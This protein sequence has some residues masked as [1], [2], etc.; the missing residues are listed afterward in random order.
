[1]GAAR[2]S[3]SSAEITIAHGGLSMTLSPFGARLVELQVPDTDGIHDDVVLGLDDVEAYARHRNVYLGATIGRVA[4]RI[5]G[6]RFSLAGT[7]YALARNEGGNH[8]HGGETRS[9]DRV[10]WAVEELSDDDLAVVAGR[11]VAFS[12][13][14]P[15]LEEGYPGALNARAAYVLSG[16]RE[17]WTI[18]TATC[19]RPCPV[20]LTHHTYWNLAGGEVEILGH[21]LMVAASEVLAVTGELLP[22]GG[23]VAVEDTPLD[24]RRARPV[25]AWLPPGGEPWPGIDHTYVLD[26]ADGSLSLAAVLGDPDSGRT[27]EIHTTEPLLQ[28]YTANRLHAFVGR[29]GRRYDVGHAV[30]LE[31]QR[32]PDAVNR[33]E[34][35]SAVLAPGETYRHV[36]CYRFGFA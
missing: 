13:Q 3:A 34:F 5:R 12:Y 9:L 27:M 1:M 29:G 8:L 4:G 7:E 25:G 36:T 22:T 26:E 16:E 24:F 14:S 21:E 6:G 31:P 17:L 18:L 23:L 19:D 35:P 30:C 10:V 20:N 2:K 28:V 15:H 33:P 11:G 32:F